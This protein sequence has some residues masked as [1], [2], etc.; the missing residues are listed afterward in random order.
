MSTQ[1]RQ[2]QGDKE[3][4]RQ[5]EASPQTLS[6]REFVRRAG[7]GMAAA[8]AGAV[9]TERKAAQASSVAPD[10]EAVGVLID[11]TR[12]SGLQLLCTLACKAINH[13]PNAGDATGCAE[14]CGALTFVA[15]D[16]QDAAGDTAQRQAPV[17][18]VSA[19]RR[20]CLPVR[21]ARC[22]NTA[23]GPVVYDARQVHR[24]PLLP[25]CVSLWRAHLRLEQSAGLDP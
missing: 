4:G 23:D 12:C 25:V 14:Q 22:A 10:D 18:A 1:K 9:L 16:C 17:Y 13:M 19:S 24:L 2:R 8:A 6:R 7:I 11:L 15:T 21:S 5:G 3:M 20:A